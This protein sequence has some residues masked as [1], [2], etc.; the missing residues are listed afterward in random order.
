MFYHLRKLNNYEFS[1]YNNPIAFGLYTNKDFSKLKMFGL[2]YVG[3][4]AKLDRNDLRKIVVSKISII[5]LIIFYILMIIPIV[6][7]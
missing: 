4:R 2:D 1:E 7:K 5:A 3:K 6:F